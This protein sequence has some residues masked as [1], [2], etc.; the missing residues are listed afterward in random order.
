MDIKEAASVYEAASFLPHFPSP[1][2]KAGEK[3]LF[4]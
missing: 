4:F 3:Q 1:K 2:N